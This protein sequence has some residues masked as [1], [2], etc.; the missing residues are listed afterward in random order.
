MLL[1]N[2]FWTGKNTQWRKKSPCNP[3]LWEMQAAVLKSERSQI[4]KPNVWT[5]FF[6]TVSLQGL[7]FTL[8]SYT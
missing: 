2:R 4:R 6:M 7:F 3:S 1:Q 8:L 5:D